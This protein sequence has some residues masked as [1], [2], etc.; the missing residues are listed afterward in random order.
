MGNCPLC[1]L[2]DHRGWPRSSAPRHT[3]PR[4]SPRR[5]RRGIPLPPPHQ[6]TPIPQL[7]LVSWLSLHHP[8]VPRPAERNFAVIL[9][10][11]VPVR[12]RID[13]LIR[14]PHGVIEAEARAGDELFTAVARR[15]L[16]DELTVIAQDQPIIG[17]DPQRL[18][19]DIVAPIDG[20]AWRNGET[21]RPGQQAIGVH[22]IIAKLALLIL[23]YAVN[24]QWHGFLLGAAP[25]SSGLRSVYVGCSMAFCNG[26]DD[27]PASPR[28]GAILALDPRCA[29]PPSGHA[30][31]CAAYRG[32]GARGVARDTPPHGSSAGERARANQ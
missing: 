16:I 22:E 7:S 14:D 28:A 6:P 8:W 12:M 29:W 27:R 32:C 20:Q 30:P 21:A 15:R 10:E 9:K 24:T 5:R 25:A 13:Q 31:S 4:S 18:I 17:D 2:S 3:W 26:R 11:E 1:N 23:P 19:A